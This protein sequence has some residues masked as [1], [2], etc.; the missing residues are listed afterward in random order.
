MDD[1]SIE[2]EVCGTGAEVT[3]H[4]LPLKSGGFRRFALCHRHA[5]ATTSVPHAEDLMDLLREEAGRRSLLSRRDPLERRQFPPR[6]E[7]RRASD[8]RRETD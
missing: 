3:E 5:G 7:G 1:G 2:C 4:E 6:P 8:G